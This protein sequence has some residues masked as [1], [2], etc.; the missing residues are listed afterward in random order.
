MPQQRST[1]TNTRQ[2]MTNTKYLKSKKLKRIATGLLAAGVLVGAFVVP[3]IVQAA[4]YQQQIDAL[5]AQNSDKRGDLN[6]LGSEAANLQDAIARLNG[7]IAN[8]QTQIAASEAKRLETVAKIAEAEAELARQK[9]SLGES[10]KA[11]YVDGQMSSLEQLATSKDL[12]EFADQEQYQ[13]SAQNKIQKTLATIKS[14]QAKL[15]T[16]KLNLERMIANLQDMRNRVAVQQAEQVR[17]LSLNQA[18]QSE[19]DGQIKANSSKI[20]NLRQQQ[21]AENARLFASS[22][23]AGRGIPGG[24]GYPWGYVSYPSSQ[25]DPWGMY[26]RE[27]VSYTAW[28]VA[29]SGKYMPYWGGRG[30]AKQWDDNA[31]AAGMKVTTAPAAQTVAVSNAGT[32]GHVMWVESVSGDGSILVSDYNQQFDGNY[33]SYWISAG[34]VAARNL[35]FVHF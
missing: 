8:L 19:L 33:R 31:R 22:G 20:A 24:G 16:E 6:N 30:N 26:K 17:L 2:H 28:K 5:N 9:T 34:T 29:S 18:Q 12:S 14:L 1:Q 21:A 23:G 35:Q 3:P 7:E 15:A 11:M 4:T 25:V 13:L 10:L 32:W 27:C